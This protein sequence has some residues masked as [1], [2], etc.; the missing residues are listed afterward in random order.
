MKDLHHIFQTKQKIKYSK[1]EKKIRIL[2]L[3]MATEVLF[4]EVMKN[5]FPPILTGTQPIGLMAQQ[6]IQKETSF[7]HNLNM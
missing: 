5:R 4:Q 6:V 1:K 2:G 3:I 7:Y